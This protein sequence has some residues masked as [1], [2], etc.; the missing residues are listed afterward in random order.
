MLYVN[1]VGKGGGVV[2]PVIFV[3]QELF[4][5]WEDNEKLSDGRDNPY[6]VDPDPYAVETIPQK[7]QKSTTGY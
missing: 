6:A 1:N 4:V 2:K 5:R 3:D 7:I